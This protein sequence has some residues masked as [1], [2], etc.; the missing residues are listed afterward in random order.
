MRYVVQSQWRHW[1]TMKDEF[2]AAKKQVERITGKLDGKKGE[3]VIGQVVGNSA[4]LRRWQASVCA[5]VFT[6]SPPLFHVSLVRSAPPQPDMPI[7]LPKGEKYQDG[8]LLMTSCH[9]LLGGGGVMACVCI[10]VHVGFRRCSGRCASQRATVTPLLPHYSQFTTKH[11]HKCVWSYLWGD[12]KM[13]MGFHPQDTELKTFNGTF[14]P[15][16]GF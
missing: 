11:P 7:T 2:K 3:V 16:N 9:R 14:K 4:V 8:Q 13:S 10:C 15:T 5:P 12:S 1:N 6:R